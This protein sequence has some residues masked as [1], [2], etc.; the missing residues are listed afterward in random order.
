VAVSY[1]ERSIAVVLSGMGSD[2]TAGLR[3][4]KQMG[5]RVIVQDEHSAEFASMPGA[6]IRAGNVDAILPLDD[7][8]PTLA[9]WVADAV[10]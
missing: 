2:G 4:I 10:R 3:M 6:A 8:A 1:R 5:G 9:A 7:I